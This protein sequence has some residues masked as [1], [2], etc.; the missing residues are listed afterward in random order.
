MGTYMHL[1][2]QLLARRASLTFPTPS[3]TTVATLVN[4]LVMSILRRF[5]LATC[6][7]ATIISL[8]G[9]CFEVGH[10]AQCEG[11]LGRLL[12]ERSLTTDH[13]KS[14]LLPLTGD[15][16]A[17][18]IKRG[19]SLSAPPYATFFKT[20]LF[21]W[22]NRILGPKPTDAP[23]QLATTLTQLRACCSSCRTVAANLDHGNVKTF[24]LD[25]VGAPGAKHL[26][27][28]MRS[29]CKSSVATWSIV[30]STP[31][32]FTVRRPDRQVLSYS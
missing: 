25:R 18:L 5:N 13:V 8:I 24:R 20:T 21:A 9:F 6:S 2:R 32:G 15:L 17:M 19:I 3:T 29:C 26:D 14:C 4:D 1:A 12:E 7:P 11:I 16:S 23:P 28:Q 30:S 31:R 22:V 10:Q 27:A